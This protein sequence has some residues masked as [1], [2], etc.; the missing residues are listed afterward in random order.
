MIRDQRSER[1]IALATRYSER[2]VRRRRAKLGKPADRR[3]MG[4]L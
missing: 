4:L 3:Q 1:D 2:S